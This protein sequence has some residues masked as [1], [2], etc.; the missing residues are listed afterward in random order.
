MSGGVTGNLSSCHSRGHFSC[1]SPQ[2]SYEV[3]FTSLQL[4]LEERE[5]GSDYLKVHSAFSLV[6]VHRTKGHRNSVL[7]AE[8]HK[9][10]DF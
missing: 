3:D 7:R 8:G 6:S 9:D 4:N 5:P 10:G 1:L 2:P